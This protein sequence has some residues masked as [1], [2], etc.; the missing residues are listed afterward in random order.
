ML[1]SGCFWGREY[2]LRRLPGVIATQVGFAGGRVAEPTYIQVCEQDTGHAEVVA[3][4]YDTRKLSTRALL[5]EFFTLHNFEFNR[6]RGTGQYRS[7]IFSLQDDEQLATARAMLET[8]RENG[9]SPATDV[10]R[11]TAF[12]RAEARHQQYCSARGMTPKRR[13]DYRIRELF[14]PVKS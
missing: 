13:D 1:G 7:A 10:E 4:T 8:L 9:F 14:A 5:T 6:G 2:H 11:V 3:V 12:Y